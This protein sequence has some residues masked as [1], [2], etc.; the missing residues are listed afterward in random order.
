MNINEIGGACMMTSMN[1]Y[2]MGGAVSRML[3]CQ[4]EY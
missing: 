3:V 2:E 1:I 4:D